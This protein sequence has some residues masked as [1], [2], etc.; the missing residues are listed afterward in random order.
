[1]QASKTLKTRLRT[2]VH[3]LTR[4]CGGLV[5]MA[6]PFFIF[7][8]TACCFIAGSRYSSPI[9]R[10]DK[11]IENEEEGGWSRLHTTY[12]PILNKLLLEH[13][14]SRLSSCTKTER[15][16][17]FAWF[18]EVVG[19]IELLTGLLPTPLLAQLLGRP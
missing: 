18:R 1:M 4:R 6:V 12:L 9:E 13:I 11:A 15:I 3:D 8:S 5:D 7:V 16:A 14:D 19:T 10:L 2:E 17:I